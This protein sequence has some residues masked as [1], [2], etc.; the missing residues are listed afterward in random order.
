MP[1]G[2]ITLT[3]NVAGLI[4]LRQCGS[5]ALKYCFGRNH[6]QE[7]ASASTFGQERCDDLTH[8]AE[9]RYAFGQLISLTLAIL[10]PPAYAGT[11]TWQIWCR[12]CSGA[13]PFTKIYPRRQTPDQSQWSLRPP[14]S[15]TGS[16]D[17]LSQ[18]AHPLS[19]TS[20]TSDPTWLLQRRRCPNAGATAV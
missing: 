17:D 4:V 16:S 2:E 6:Q 10:C 5:C 18:L 7:C 11:G 15:S 20:D 3:T 1:P 13:T 9:T 19:F 8:A 12:G 14:P